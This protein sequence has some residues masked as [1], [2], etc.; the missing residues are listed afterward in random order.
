MT[1]LATPEGTARYARRHPDAA[2]SHWR[3][4]R[5]LTLSSVGFGSYLGEGSR[6]ARAAYVA[7]F[8][9]GLRSGVNVLDTASV[10]RSRLSERDV[11]AA[12]A[13]SGVPREEFVVAT[14]GG[15]LAPD[16]E[17]GLPPAEDL[18]RRYV[19]TGVLDEGDVVAG[20]HAM[21]PRFLAHELRAS[22]A[23]LRLDAVDV[24]FVHNPEAQLTGGIPRRAFESRL[25]AAFE[26]LETERREG[27]IG[28][29]GLATWNGFRVGPERPEHLPLE[30]ILALAREA[31]GED[32]GFR[33]IELP[34]N[35]GM[36]EAAARPTQEWRGRR[37]PLLEAAREAGLLV[38]GSATLL[39]TR[40]LGRIEPALRE[41][42]GAAT[43]VEAALQFSR[44]TPGITSALVGTGRPDHAAENAAVRRR[45]LRPEGIEAILG[46]GEGA[47]H[48]G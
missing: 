29:Y 16:A 8:E 27:R 11:G 26:H 21:T 34:Y 13:A 14:K 31:G 5:G 39:Q 22:L 3:A 43:D 48:R 28:C 24:Y 37:V 42:L 47:Y 9:T 20:Q 19:E 4:H 1:T 18:R 2:S 36:P 35:V 6:E 41:A 38:L 30:R 40:L 46:P 17:S 23:S 15:Y 7:A 33:A 45:P 25:R 12:I 44:S 32:H 10:Y